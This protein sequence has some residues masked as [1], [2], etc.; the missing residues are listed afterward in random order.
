M[1]DGFAAAGPL[2]FQSHDQESEEDEEPAIVASD[3]ESIG[4]GRSYWS[5]GPPAARSSNPML[6]FFNIV[7]GCLGRGLAFDPPGT[8]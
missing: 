8:G 4:G 6:R 5:A 7:L 3:P 1:A 2:K